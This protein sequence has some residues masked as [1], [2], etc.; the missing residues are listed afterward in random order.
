MQFFPK[1]STMN[2]DRRNQFALLLPATTHDTV[3][4]PAAMRLWPD[5]EA[6]KIVKTA[7]TGQ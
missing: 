4:V 6:A 3:D 5:G 1:I 7:A 2:D